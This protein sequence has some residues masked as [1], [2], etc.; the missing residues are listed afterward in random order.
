MVLFPSGTDWEKARRSA[1]LVTSGHEDM[2]AGEIET[3]IL[4]HMHPELVRDGYQAVLAS[5]V[6]TK[7]V[8]VLVR[9]TS[10]GRGR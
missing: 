6:D 4:L 1:G 10:P 5:L 2:H 3:S 9:A 8:E 7:T